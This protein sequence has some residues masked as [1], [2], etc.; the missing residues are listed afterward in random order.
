MKAT[1]FDQRGRAVP[2]ERILRDLLGRNRELAM[3]ILGMHHTAPK[4]ELPT[5]RLDIAIEEVD[6]RE[7]VRVRMGED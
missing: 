5:S 6:G 3:Q 7:S 2:T 1:Y 4:P